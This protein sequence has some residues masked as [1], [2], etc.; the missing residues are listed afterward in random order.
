MAKLN[1]IKRSLFY[2]PVF[3][4]F[5]LFFLTCPALCQVPGCRDALANNY[6][7]SA[8]IN[9]GSCTYNAIGYSPIIK[10]DPLTDTLIETS[11]LQMAGNFLWSFND[12]GGSAAIYKIDTL[13]NT[14]L[15]RV[16]LAGAVNVDWEDIAFD[17]SNFYLGDFGNNANGARTDLRIYK[18]PISAIPGHVTN[19]VVTIPATQVS[20][21]NFTYNDQPQPP[22]PGPANSTKFDCEAMIVDNGK[23]HLFTKNWID[24]NSQHYVI[25]GLAAGNYVAQ[26]VE[27]LA[28]AYLVTGADKSPGKEVVT[29]LGYQNTGSASH[30]IHLL[31]D[32]TGGNYFNGN[33]RRIDL[34]DASVMG[35]AEGICFRNGGYGY[36]SNEKFTRTFG[37]F[38][39]TVNQKLRSFDLNSY[40]TFIEPAVYTFNGNGNWNVAAN[41][42][43]AS[44]PPATVSPGSEIIIDPITGG[45]CILNV[46]YTLSAGAKLTIIQSQNFIIQGNLLINE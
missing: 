37:P 28:T 14:I 12:G 17:G 26:P 19:P 27:I 43:N 6:N 23:I 33:K 45:Q 18:F 24:F 44:I 8:T 32:Y 1:F 3:Q 5:T 25:N 35:Q 16:Y 2:L 42:A 29:L 30:F 11:G 4:T 15:Q 46:P 22:V 34:P 9:D 31:S 40:V 20:V 41:W 39:F 13:S 21:I 36:I 38:T 10:V 7:S